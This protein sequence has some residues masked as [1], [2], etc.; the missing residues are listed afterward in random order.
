[1]H[2]TRRAFLQ[3][4]GAAGLIFSVA[5]RLGGQG[6][7]S[8]GIKPAPRPKFSGRPW[9]V[10]F[11]DVAPHAGL[12][13]PTVYGDE[14]TK[15]YIVEAN[16]PGIAFY[17]YDH[18]GWLDVFVPSGTRL[19]GFPPGHEPTNRLYH[20]N[21]DGTF[22]DVT[23]KAGLTR[24]GWCYGVCVGD[25]DNDGHDDLFLTYYGK[26]VLYHNNGDGTFSDVTEKAGLLETE[27]RYGTGCTFVDY[28]RDGFLDLFVSRY[29]A[30]DLAKTPVGG[31]SRY[32]KYLDVP[33]NCGP[34][35]LQQET[36]TLYHNNGDGTFTDVSAKAGI[37]KA[38][39]RYGLTAVAFDYNNDGWPDLFVACDST[40]NLL[41]RNNHD[42]TFTEVGME[43]GCAVSGDGQEEA[44]MGVGV[45]D[46]DADG[47]LDLFL[48]HFSSD[49]PILYHNLHG[50][51]FDDVTYAAGLAVNT[52]Y[53]CWG[54][55]FA[56]FDNDGWLD[57]FHVTG[58][59]YPEV[60]KVDPDYKFKT[61]R[62]VYRN[63]GNGSFEE[64][65][66]MCGAPVLEPH[67][68]RGCTFGD[69]NN[70]GNIDVL[71]LNMS[72]PPSLLLNQNHSSH[73]WLN[74]KLVGTRS[75]RSAIG[76]RVAVTSG[77]RRQIRE[78]L[79]ASSYISQSDLRQHFGLGAARKVD[80]IEVRWPS[81]RVD[82]VHDVDVDQFIVLEEDRGIRKS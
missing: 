42:G 39:S 49:T 11:T 40:P 26:N 59:V 55:G 36:C 35:G 53:V 51:F 63:L 82:R 18:D 58:T 65:S 38:G 75:N 60:E 6:M 46:Y 66:D 4:A 23:Q 5:A 8:R 1:M 70:D 22:T 69:F 72:E 64:V 54:V 31:S 67:S 7:A 24:T 80:Q 16:G 25:Y 77:E 57:I 27:T 13:S 48:P 44:N 28:D 12:T 73:H 10:T 61:P 76:A 62:L 52:K 45:G 14:Y 34:L 32:C 21:R 20:N 30:M 33:V 81:G 79:S 9:P 56:D 3:S 50:E 78:V 15:R 68:S 47:Y 43:A 71:I 41:Y 74:I 17:D 29:I 37:L 2:L 19:E